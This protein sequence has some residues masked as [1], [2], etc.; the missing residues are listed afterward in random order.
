MQLAIF[1]CTEVA[2]PPHSGADSKVL[3]LI[4]RAIAISGHACASRRFTNGVVAVR[5]LFAALGGD[6]VAEDAE[7][8][9]GGQVVMGC[10]T[11]VLGGGQQDIGTGLPSSDDIL[12]A[13]LLKG[14]QQVVCKGEVVKRSETCSATG[15]C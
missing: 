8:G 7:D 6:M 2:A 3:F 11:E 12:I 10:G 9:G 13:R 5:L 1:V 14:V 4:A 15:G